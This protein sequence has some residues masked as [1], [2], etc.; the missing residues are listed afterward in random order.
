MVN[1]RVLYTSRTAILIAQM[2]KARITA[3]AKIE[4]REEKQQHDN[5]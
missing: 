1:Q 4:V 3:T 5:N 2:D